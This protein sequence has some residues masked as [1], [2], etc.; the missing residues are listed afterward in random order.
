MSAARTSLLLLAALVTSACE[1]A[2]EAPAPAASPLPRRAPT[3]VALG[4][5]VYP[6]S[7]PATDRVPLRLV[8]GRYQPDPETP[9][10][11]RLV[12]EA[13]LEALHAVGDLDGDGSPDA[14]VVLPWSGGGSG[15]FHELFVVLNEPAGLRVLDGVPLGD[16]IDLKSIVVQDGRVRLN[17]IG[18]KP[19]DAACCPSQLFDK[20]YAIDAGRLIEVPVPGA[21]L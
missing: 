20:A 5:L 9:D 8:D 14:A 3:F 13:A 18:A 16:R 4:N 19:D 15:T 21:S 10:S 1:P 11:E 12:A 6:L 7:G 17:F 2:V